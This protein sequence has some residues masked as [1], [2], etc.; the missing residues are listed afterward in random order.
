MEF[1]CV[2]CHALHSRGRNTR[3]HAVQELSSMSGLVA[4]YASRLRACPEHKTEQSRLWC[5]TCAKLVCRECAVLEHRDHKYSSLAA[6]FATRE[7]QVLQRH[8]AV[9]TRVGS[10]QEAI[11]ALEELE[12][13]LA[14]NCARACEDVA[15]A[16]QAHVQLL[17]QRQTELT[18]QCRALAAQKRG[19]LVGQREALE[20]ALADMQ[21]ASSFAHTCMTSGRD[22]PLAPLLDYDALEA[23][24]L[25]LRTAELVLAPQESAALSFAVQSTACAEA[26][27]QL[28]TV[29]GKATNASACTASGAGVSTAQQGAA[30]EF[31]VQAMDYA[32]ARR[33]VGGDLVQLTLAA[34]G[35]GGG[36][37][38]V[39]VSAQS[40]LAVDDRKNGAYVCRYVPPQ[41]GQLSLAV[42]VRGV[43]IKGSPFTV[44]VGP[45]CDAECVYGSDF[46][47]KG[48][49]Y[50]LGTKGRTQAF[51]EPLENAAIAVGTESSKEYGSGGRA[52]FSRNHKSDNFT[53]NAPNQWYY[54]CRLWLIADLYFLAVQVSVAAA[55]CKCLSYSLHSSART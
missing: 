31:A 9:Q 6:L 37:G 50:W 25:R 22:A 51:V 3:Q 49:M 40:A 35:E 11:A 33:D 16:T 36:G 43:H 14:H 45:A 10:V 42:R 32:G 8:A 52:A 13:A 29:S 21:A 19:R 39:D 17:L 55:D 38:G 28:G 1:L 5:S 30:A 12:E 2:D 41:Q 23:D 48:I 20:Q 44:D 27:K 47:E 54:A 46:D 18:A 15:A 24:L 34:R 4:S 7:P 53:A 26:I